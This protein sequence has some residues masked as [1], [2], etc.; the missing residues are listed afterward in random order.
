MT[1]EEE[2]VEIYIPAAGGWGLSWCVLITILVPI[3][4]LK[5]TGVNEKSVEKQGGTAKT[6][7]FFDLERRKVMSWDG[8]EL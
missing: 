2:E 6:F 1:S 7:V 4:A 8:L 3:F 5:V